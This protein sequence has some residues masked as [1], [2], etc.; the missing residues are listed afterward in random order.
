MKRSTFIIANLIAFSLFSGNPVIKDIPSVETA[1]YKAKQ[2]NTVFI[3][4][5]F[6]KATIKNPEQF[7]KLTG[8][9]IHQVDLVYT[10][11]KT[12]SSFNQEELNL[13]RINELIAAY[14]A[15]ENESIKWNLIEQTASNTKTSAQ[16]ENHGFVIH[17]GEALTYQSLNKLFPKKQKQFDNYKVTSNT[18]TTLTYSSGTKIKIPANAVTYEDGT[19]VEGEYTLKYREFRNPAEIAFSGIPMTYNDN[20]V[21]K[22]FNSVGM[23]EVRAEKD[24]K[25]LKLDKPI[26]YDFNCTAT[27]PNVNFY[28]MNDS[29]GEWKD[30]QKINGNEVNQ[31]EK[32]NFQANAINDGFPEKGSVQVGNKKKID[33]SKGKF[34]GEM[35]R[36]SEKYPG[37]PYKLKYQR[38]QG[39]FFITF[40]NRAQKVF[41][42]ELNDT[43]NFEVISDKK[44]K[45]DSANFI[46]TMIGMGLEDQ[47]KMKNGK[48]LFFNNGTLW[49]MSHIFPNIKAGNLIHGGLFFG[50]EI[51]VKGVN[52]GS[53]LLAEGADQG[54]TYP[55]L[56][57]GLN[58]EEFGVYNC[59]QIYRVASA[60][61]IK[62][63]YKDSTGQTIKKQH[64]ACLI[65]KNVNG[66]FS[67]HPNTIT[68]NSE[69]ENYI[70]LF[71]KDKKVYIA[72]PQEVT[73]KVNAS[74]QSQLTLIDVTDKIKTPEDLKAY[75][76]L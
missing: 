7:K 67:F 4:N 11:Y 69:S 17:Y 68:L 49:L 65:D 54:H 41:D 13:K 27:K 70:V 53:T 26:E 21:E 25:N 36:Y 59:D 58:S 24:G 66:S 3:K 57:R 31:M 14:P 2:Q 63:T 44:I 20:G 29:T 56:V 48:G 35:E 37:Y 75:L 60:K 12:T 52:T 73:S 6:G 51:G 55:N 46:N 10:K 9:T 16:S 62:P 76:K 43:I 30:I 34:S 50:N 19:P 64:V 23:L 42:D 18:A 33:F 28:Q 61:T 22:N 47:S 45:L 72:D 74:N 40:N 8:K 39:D 71:T 15:L 5:D 32:N 1:S 38:N